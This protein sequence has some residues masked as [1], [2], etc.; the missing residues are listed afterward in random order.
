MLVRSKTFL[1]ILLT[2]FIDS[3]GLAIVYP[4]FTPLFL[5]PNIHI[6][7]EGATPFSRTILLGFLIASFPLAQFFGAPF[8]G[9]LSD[10]IGR[11]KIFLVTISG[12]IVGYLL[13]GMGIHLKEIA[14]LWGGRTI[15]GFFAG[16]L[17][18]CLAS[19]AD[20]SKTEEEKERNFGWI[21]AMGGLGFILAISA[22]AL[23]SNPN[24][25]YFFNPEVPF[26]LTSFFLCINLALILYFFKEV[27]HGM[28][29]DTRA[30]VHSLKNIVHSLQV[31]RIRAILIV[32]FLFMLAWF[33]TMQFL[34]VYLIDVFKI[35]QNITTLTF[36]CIG[37][38]WTLANFLVHP[39]LFRRFP[40]HKIF[41]Y[42]MTA[43]G[44]F[45]LLTLIPHQLLYLFLIHFFM[46]ALCAALSWTNGLA[47]LSLMGTKALQG[48][49]L[50]VN[51]AMSASAMILGPIIGGLLAAVN[52]H[53]LY[54]FTGLCSL[55]GALILWKKGKV[56]A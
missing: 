44:V 50:G 27:S 37:I 24:I 12:G 20:I 9:M 3:F 43:L 16:N 19:I 48:S 55:L 54:L 38:V 41:T 42:T 30:F 49:L 6:F 47:T 35:T 2:Y 52:I 29:H 10:R 11:K 40:P 56:L 25:A 7:G 28:P 46:I 45:L 36:T 8:F 31:E 23:L 32:Y 34:S 21:A 53:Y 15:A 22:G 26:Y 13:T 5:N 18:L 39:F 51:Q 4:I 33:P 1:P 14:F 17:T